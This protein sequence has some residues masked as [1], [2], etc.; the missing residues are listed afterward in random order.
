MYDAATV[1]QRAF[2]AWGRGVGQQH[3]PHHAAGGHPGRPIVRVPPLR[4]DEAAQ[5][6]REV[7][8]ARPQE[9]LRQNRYENAV[10]L[11]SIDPSLFIDSNLLVLEAMEPF[12]VSFRDV[13]VG[14]R[15]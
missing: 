5:H 12:Y 7:P 6:A 11:L 3:Q 2:P 14:T 15:R 9:P 4:F 10:R 1:R 13:V 8:G